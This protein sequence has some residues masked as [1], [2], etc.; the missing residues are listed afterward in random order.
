MR[1][2]VQAM[3]VTMEQPGLRMQQ[4]VSPEAWGGMVVEYFECADR[5][6]FGPMFVGLLNDL[7]PC[8]LVLPH[9]FQGKR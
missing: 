8:P 6:D 3:P 1:E 4:V 2:Q 9:R 7:C 5:I